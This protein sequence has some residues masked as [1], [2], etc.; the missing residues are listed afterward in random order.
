MIGP[1]DLDTPSSRTLAGG[2]TQDENLEHDDETDLPLTV[3]L[4]GD[5]SYV[6]EFEL[7]ADRVMELLGIK[8]SRLTQISGKELRVGRIRRGRYVAP[9]YRQEDVDMYRSWTRATA[10]HVKS[11]SLLHEAAA[12]LKD[13]SSRVADALDAAASETKDAVQQAVR[14]GNAKTV[15]LLDGSL[16]ELTNQVAAFAAERRHE[17]KRMDAWL[18]KQDTRMTL[19]ETRLDT[20]QAALLLAV[21]DLGEITSLM[22]SSRVDSEAIANDTRTKT[23]MLLQLL[24]ELADGQATLTA[25]L[26]PAVKPR[27]GAS[28]RSKRLANVA[29]RENTLSLSATAVDKRRSS[30]KSGSGVSP[31]PRKP[32]RGSI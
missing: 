15:A 20:H 21:R 1:M 26:H 19:I 5:E 14:D 25:T 28:A 30:Q 22:R 23:A 12:A 7:D 6:S 27:R 4:R 32:R 9:V 13:E 24:T 17:A 3:W 16:T 29:S 11:S 31:R 2:V 8:R 18:S 10:S